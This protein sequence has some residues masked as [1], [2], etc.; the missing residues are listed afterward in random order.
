[1]GNGVAHR[2]F[3]RRMDVLYQEDSVRLFIGGANSQRERSDLRRSRHVLQR[4]GF[5]RAKALD[6]VFFGALAMDRR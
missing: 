1:M 3:P 2:L 6:C 5:A 4:G